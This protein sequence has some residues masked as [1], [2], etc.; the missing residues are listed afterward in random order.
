MSQY[1]RGY[2]AEYEAKINLVHVLSAFDFTPADDCQM[3]PK[4]K[5]R[6]TQSIAGGLPVHA[7]AL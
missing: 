1:I 3:P 2:Q 4:Y 6:L 7:T 5:V